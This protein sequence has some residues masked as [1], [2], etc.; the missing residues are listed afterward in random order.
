MSDNN[1]RAVVMVRMTSDMHLTAKF[2][3]AF[4]K[5]SLNQFCIDAIRTKINAVRSEHPDLAKLDEYMQG[6]LEKVL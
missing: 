2:F 5:K 4:E 3:A 1:R 6:T